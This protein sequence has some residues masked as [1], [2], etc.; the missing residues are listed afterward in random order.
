MD[1]LTKAKNI[2]KEYLDTKIRKT[3][4]NN[5]LYDEEPPSFQRKSVVPKLSFGE[6]APETVP[7]FGYPFVNYSPLNKNDMVGEKQSNKLWQVFSTE[8]TVNQKKEDKLLLAQM[9]DK[10]ELN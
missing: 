1:Q 7:V 9:I 5:N 4:S 2:N 3:T 8:I 6:L 10:M